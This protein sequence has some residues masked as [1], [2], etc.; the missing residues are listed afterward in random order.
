LGGSISGQHEENAE[1][2]DFSISANEFNANFLG[3]SEN[4]LSQKKMLVQKKNQIS[5]VLNYK[6][7]RLVTGKS[8]CISFYAFDPVLDSMRKK[9]IKLNHISPI[10]LRRKTGEHYIKLLNEKLINGWNPWIESTNSN[11]YKH[12]SD[13]LNNYRLYLN[14]QLNKDVIRPDTFRSYSS[15]L[16]MLEKY[17]EKHAKIKYIYQFNQIFCIGFLDYIFVERENTARTRNNYLT[18]LGVFAHYLVQHQYLTSKPTD[19]ITPIKKRDMSK[20]Q[21]SVI[22]FDILQQIGAYWR[23]KN[24]N[25]LLAIYILNKCFIRH[26][27][28]SFLKIENINFE[29]STILIP[30]EFSKNRL[31]QTPTIPDDL[32]NLMLELGIDKYPED[33]YL[34]SDDC[35][36]G[37]NYQKPKFLSDKWLRMKKDLQLPAEYQMYSLKDTGITSL[38]KSGVDLL[39]VRDQ[40]RHYDIS[41]TN[42]YLPTD[43]DQ[44]DENIK[45]YSNVF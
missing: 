4:E 7:P 16:S 41:I 25:M 40:A 39:A 33:Y 38:V 31:S 11:A 29:K 6:P 17:N 5:A 3:N 8:W 26:R 18:T 37:K 1:Y 19:G 20:K 10:S 43:S 23:E 22:P 28:M 27:E 44:A 12:F 14:H 45:S 24:K 21:R 32:K 35:K 36:P 34:F 30:A 9:R 15:S 13:V 2:T 42:K